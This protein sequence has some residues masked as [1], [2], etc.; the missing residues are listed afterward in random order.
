MVNIELIRNEWYNIDRNLPKRPSRRSFSEKYENTQY[1]SL[2]TCLFH[3]NMLKGS[4]I[5]RNTCNF[6]DFSD[7]DSKHLFQHVKRTF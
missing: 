2:L 1:F 3:V 5:L 7:E 6:S 4:T